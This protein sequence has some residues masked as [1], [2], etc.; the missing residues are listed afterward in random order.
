MLQRRNLFFSKSA[1]GMALAFVAL[2]AANTLYFVLRTSNPVIEA[3][4]WFYLDAFLRKAINGTLGFSDFFIKRMP[5]D[6][7]APLFRLFSLINLHFFDLDFAFDAA[8]GV[9]GAVACAC[10]Y[11]KMI[12]A[13][14]AGN[15][16][17]LRILCW[18]T[19]S[20]LIFS[21]NSVGIWTWSLVALENVTTFII[22]LF[23]FFTWHALRSQRY[24][25]LLVA[26]L[27][28]GISSDDSAVI[29]SVA[30]IGALGIGLIADPTLRSPASWKAGGG[31]ILCLLAARTW[32]AYMPMLSTAHHPLSSI[33]HTLHQRFLDGGWWQWVLLPLVLP[34]YFQSPLQGTAP[35]AWLAIQ[36]IL[37]VIFFLAHVAFWRRA[38][39]VEYS[40]PV[41]AAVSIMLLTY[42]WCAGIIL[43]RVSVF[44]N[45]YL[46]SPR[47]VLLYDGHIIAL[48]L[49]WSDW[50]RSFSLRQKL[51]PRLVKVWLPALGC[52]ALIAV[53][54]PQSLSAWH[55]RR[56]EWVYFAAQASQIDGI[57]RDPMHYTDCALAQP[58]CQS[59]SETRYSL[60]K[61]LQENQ[62]NIY[63]PK[64]LRRHPYL[65]KPIS[66]G[67]G[68][69]PAS[70]K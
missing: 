39:S 4:A 38:L 62:L 30:V 70:K 16:R 20:C 41:F 9:F 63:S 37:G 3:D 43:W 64:V 61:L 19:V 52:V 57:A 53:Q 10:I 66:Y 13:G 31:I 2:C 1:S 25:P 12:V 46:N 8:V 7:A 65:P 33:F 59:S 42:G 5:D 22:L 69:A 21:L 24:I 56:Y 58:I 23:V 34:V 51:E 48:I 44:G 54:V 40:L 67:S 45:D 47:Y 17:T 6:H 27:I 32:Y 15:L 26:A 11:Y 50:L 60:T 49:M 14:P 18:V 36:I 28:L 35:H 68:A 29:A 55:M